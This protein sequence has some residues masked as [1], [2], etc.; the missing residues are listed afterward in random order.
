M[1]IEALEKEVT[2]NAKKQETV[3]DFITIA[4]AIDRYHRLSVFPQNDQGFSPQA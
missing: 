1:R 3:A 4:I 2:Q